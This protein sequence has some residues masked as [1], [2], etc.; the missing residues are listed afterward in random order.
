MEA[1]G[2]LFHIIKE[3]GGTE[4]PCP[5]E[6]NR[7]LHRVS[8]LSLHDVLSLLNTTLKISSVMHVTGLGSIL[9]YETCVCGVLFIMCLSAVLH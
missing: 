2:R 7:A 1:E 5:Q 4:S 6:P 3:M 9:F 8:L